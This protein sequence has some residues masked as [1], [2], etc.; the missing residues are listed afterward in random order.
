MSGTLESTTMNKSDGPV[1]GDV[2]ASAARPVGRALLPLGLPARGSSGRPLFLDIAQALSEAI[3]CFRLGPGQRL[4]SSRDLSRQLGV[5]R[6]TV[7]AAYRELLSEG[8]LEARP[9]SGTFVS[10][11]LPGDVPSTALYSQ[12]GP[13]MTRE[14]GFDL[15]DATLLS[16]SNELPPGATAL[17]GG[18]PDLRL[19]PWP[20]LARAYRRALRPSTSALSYGDPRGH[21]ALRRQ[22]AIYLAHSR[23]LD[24][25]EEDI[26][27]TRGSQMALALT[28][29]VLLKPGDVVAV[30]SF[31]YRPAWEALRRA[32]ARLEPIPVD[33]RGLDTNALG[34]LC[35]QTRIRAVY[36]TPHHQYPTTVTLSP[37]RRLKLLDLARE[38]RFAILEDDYDHEFHYQGQPRLPLAA[39]DSFGVVV[40]VGTLSKVLAP[41]LRV[42][43]L[44]ARPDLLE[45]V[46]RERF[47]IDRQGDQATE[48][49]IAEL[50]EDGEL[51]RHLR[52]T[53]RIYLERRDHCVTALGELFGRRLLFQVPEG[54]MSLW[55]RARNTNVEGWLNA[56][57]R[58]GIHFQT[59]GQFAWSPSTIP[60]LRLG[61]A[62][63]TCSEM[64]IALE[65]LRQTIPDS[66]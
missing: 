9:G 8:W 46:C 16:P 32:G 65:V 25:G 14:S 44:V 33:R 1:D 27:I 12:G 17:Y 13:R 23:G 10:R 39:M 47:Y 50:I 55:I 11:D 63:L 45:R 21:L 7:L 6:N 19:V 28:A 15:D 31:G 56:S 37:E 3:R 22:L 29:R 49:S 20:Q 2:P 38:H 26:L 57:S 35:K 61:Y 52:R 59:G 40:Y 53:R 36:V 4:P 62:C 66:A 60:F 18:L 5:H 58:R 43:Y 54:G 48:R 64:K 24:I 30:E 51:V 42:G 34:D 41:G